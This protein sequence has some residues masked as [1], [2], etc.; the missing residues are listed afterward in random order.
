M[1]FILRNE[2]VLNNA[3]DYLYA[4]EL[5]EDKPFDLLIKDHKEKR[6]N[7]Q[8]ALYWSWLRILSQETG[9]STK[10]FHAFYGD[11]FLPKEIDKIAG[12][13]VEMIKSTTELGMKA[14]T[15]YLKLIEAHASSFFGIMLPHPGDLEW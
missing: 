12:K 1:K 11:E 10:A 2:A 4:L 13:R 6:T 5:D 3:I 7:D 14:F 9:D 15:E 8:N